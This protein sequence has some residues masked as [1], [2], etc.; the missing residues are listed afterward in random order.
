MELKEISDRMALQKLAIDYVYAID[1]RKWD[2]LDRIFTADAYIDYRAMGGIDGKY[3]VIRQWLPEALKHFPAYMHF[4]GN[5]Q[6]EIDGDRAVGKV[7]CFNPMVIPSQSGGAPD[8]MFLGL[9]YVD[10]YVRTEDGWRIGRRVEQKCYDYGMPD[11]MKRA[12]KLA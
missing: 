2:A 10:A 5:H 4:I 8:T 9:W 12:L 7:A 3:S 6:I 1:D 11:W